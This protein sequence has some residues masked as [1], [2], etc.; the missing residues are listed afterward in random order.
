MPPKK[1]RFSFISG[2]AV[3]FFFALVLLGWWGF[4]EGIGI[5]GGVYVWPFQLVTTD[6]WVTGDIFLTLTAFL[7]GLA[8]VLP[9]RMDEP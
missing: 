6:V 3:G 4:S 2:A 8:V 7:T 1:H 5:S 9:L